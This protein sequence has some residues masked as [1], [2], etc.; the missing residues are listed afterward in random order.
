MTALDPSRDSSHTAA[1]PNPAPSFGRFQLLRLLGKHTRTL[2]WLAIDPKSGVECILVMPRAQAADRV[3]LQRHLQA[4]RKAMRVTH[5]G[6]AT[7]IEVGEHDR[8]LY[9]AYERGDA[10]TLG[11]KTPAQGIAAAEVAP[12]CVQVLDGLAFAHE[13]GLAHRDIQSSMVLLG[14]QGSARLLGLEIA[15]TVTE[16]NTGRDAAALG[17]DSLQ[18]QR[19]DA[20]RDVLAFGLVMHHALSGQRPLELE[21]TARV[22]ALIPP[23]GREIVR[24]PWTTG[25]PIPEPLRVIANR[26]TDRQERQRYHNARTLARA[27]EGWI[28]A[29][30]ETDGGPLALLLDR[31]RSIGPLPS[32]PGASRRV[33]R[34]ALME[35]ERTNE[36]AEM[37]LQDPALTFELLRAVNTAQVRGSMGSGSGPVLTLRRAIALVG[38]DGVR[39]A[40]LSLRDWPGPLSDAAAE[41]LKQAVERAQQAAHIAQLLRPPGYDAEVVYLIA[42]LQNLGRLVTHYHF[43]EEAAQIHQLMQ[44]EP[45]NDPEAEE[46]PEMSEEAASFAVLGVD[47]E[48]LGGAV[49][50]HW[51]LD[52]SVLHMIHRFALSTPIRSI[53]TDDDMLRATASCANEVMDAL[54]RPA[55][56]VLPAL[57]HVAQRYARALNL[58]LRDLQLA[59]Q[60]QSPHAVEPPPSASGSGARH[61]A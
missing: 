26:A 9:A 39:R 15:V 31:L 33:A 42:L 32:L 38:L 56:R 45:T 57:Q 44:P 4:A 46:P 30:A 28:K 47:I 25:R 55:Q 43:P 14:A 11:E 60:G 10:V 6:L 34:L 61:A 23:A 5:P 53:E 20:E 41:Q 48:V 24:L 17:A 35:R 50:R 12:W 3:G 52:E 16:G 8:W 51:G 59:A 13:A 37:V 19:R 58:S 2:V 49:A 22:I 1:Q 7:A 29:D 40:A 54:R 36:L 21:D 27:I 18:A